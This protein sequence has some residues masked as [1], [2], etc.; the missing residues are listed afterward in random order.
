MKTQESPLARYRYA[1]RGE[2]HSAGYRTLSEFSKATDVELSKIS[3]IVNGWEL[4][5]PRLEKSIAAGLGMSI[6]QLRKIL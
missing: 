2:I 5:T 4:P 3:R 6:S 1:L